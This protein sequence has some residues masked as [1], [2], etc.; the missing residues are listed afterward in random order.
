MNKTFEGK[1]SKSAALLNRPENIC[2]LVSAVNGGFHNRTDHI[3]GV[4]M[5][6]RFSGEWERRGA[7]DR[8]FRKVEL[9]FFACEDWISPL[10]LNMVPS[11]SF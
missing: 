1:K 10:C 2:I 5:C 3:V 9:T 7:G 6:L 4:L 8:R 11:G